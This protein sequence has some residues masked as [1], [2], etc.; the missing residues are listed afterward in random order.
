MSV[1]VDITNNQV[2]VSEAVTNVVEVRAIGPK[3]DPGITQDT[4]SLLLTA[5]IS[6]DILTFTKG[7]SDTFSLTLPSGGSSTNTGSLLVTASVSDNIVTFEKGDS[8]TFDITIVSSSFAT[9]AGSATSASYVLASKIDDAVPVPSLTITSLTS[10][11]ITTDTINSGIVSASTYQG[12]F[13]FDNLIDVPVFVDTQGE[14]LEHQLAI[15]VDNTQGIPEGLPFDLP[16][17][18]DGNPTI[19]GL[20]GLT[21]DGSTLKIEGVVTGSNIPPNL[22][23][24][25]G[26]A[27]PD[28]LV[29]FVDTTD[30]E[31]PI[32]M[33]FYLP[34]N[35]GNPTVEAISGLTFSGS[36]LSITGDISASGGLT[37]GGDLNLDLGDHIRF[38][39]QL[40][41]TK[42]NNGEL[43]LYGGTNSTD[44]GF[45]F[46]TWNGATYDSSF[47]LKNNGIVTFISSGSGDLIFNDGCEGSNETAIQFGNNGRISGEGGDFNF[48]GAGNDIVF[49]TGSGIRNITT[50]AFTI[51][52]SNGNV[53]IGTETPGEKLTVEGNIS[54]SATINT[55]LLNIPQSGTGPLDGAVYFGTGSVNDAGYIYDDNNNI[56]IGYNDTDTFSISETNL[57]VATNLEATLNVTA[58]GDIIAGADST[59]GL[60]LTSPNGTTYRLSVDNSG[61]LSTSVV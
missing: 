44:G 56:V 48:S 12:A 9:L 4:G 10:S 22:I 54:S 31:L 8:S 14:P 29:R 2:T 7:N 41:I 36:I 32:S 27:N 55:K 24:L 58:S 59:K 30:T 40:A 21:F 16:L 34:V 46:F 47:T 13:S 18:N 37:I 38:G 26:N 61:N 39:T 19:K 20:S 50:P 45:E 52:G 23:N 17:V 25:Q 33:P 28:Q 43:K 11:I 5:S 35:D 6:D 3:G 57:Q 49:H 53:G 42:E 15:F 1:T 60:I 51:S